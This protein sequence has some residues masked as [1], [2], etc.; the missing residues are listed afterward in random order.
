MKFADKKYAAAEDG[1]VQEILE[2]EETMDASKWL[3]KYPRG[4]FSSHALD[5]NDPKGTPLAPV[6]AR[7]AAA[8]AQRL[9]VHHGD[10]RFFVGLIVVL[11]VDT[12]ARN[13][14]FA[15]EPELSELCIQRIQR[16]YGQKY[17]YYSQ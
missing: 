3:Q 15:I 17:L 12:K 4:M 6:V 10:G 1:R 5:P 8:G 13:R 2:S 16:D 9:V 11:P 14:I 7:L